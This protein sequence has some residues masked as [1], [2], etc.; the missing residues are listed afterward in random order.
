MSAD[1]FRDAFH[2]LFK[3]NIVKDATPD[4]SLAEQLFLLLGESAYCGIAAKEAAIRLL[5]QN[6]NNQEF[7]KILKDEYNFSIFEQYRL[8]AQYG[9]GALFAE[10]F[11]SKKK[12]FLIKIK[13]RFADTLCLKLLRMLRMRVYGL[14]SGRR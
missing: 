4:T 6:S 2:E 14:I 11:P 12:A 8:T 5:F 1:L 10:Y 13:I 3:K 9:T 7:E